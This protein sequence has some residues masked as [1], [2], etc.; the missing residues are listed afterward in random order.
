MSRRRRRD[1]RIRAALSAEDERPCSRPHAKHPRWSAVRRA[2]RGIYT[3]TAQLTGEKRS[4]GWRCSSDAGVIKASALRTDVRDAELFSDARA[5][6]LP[7]PTPGW[8]EGKSSPGCPSMIGF[9]TGS[10][11]EC[12]KCRLGA[13]PGEYSPGQSVLPGVTPSPP[14]PSDGRREPDPVIPAR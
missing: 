3:R 1:E 10:F 4:D 7:N 5:Q 11:C 6:P 9:C 13:A 12:D 2:A 14:S 8:L